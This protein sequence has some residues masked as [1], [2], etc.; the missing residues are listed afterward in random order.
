MKQKGLTKKTLIK[1]FSRNGRKRRKDCNSMFY[2]LQRGGE[3]KWQDL[4]PNHIG[5][6]SFESPLSSQF[7]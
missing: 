5:V 3:V 7:K 6:R 1:K 4:T 2:Y